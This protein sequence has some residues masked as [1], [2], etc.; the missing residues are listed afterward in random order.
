MDGAGGKEGTVLGALRYRQKAE[1]C[2]AAL[3]VDRF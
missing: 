2:G 1:S 3:S